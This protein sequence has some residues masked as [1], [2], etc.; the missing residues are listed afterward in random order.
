MM[1]KLTNVNEKHFNILMIVLK[2]I[3]KIVAGKFKRILY[4]KL[5][6]SY[7]KFLK[8]IN[9][10]ADFQPTKVNIKQINLR[11]LSPFF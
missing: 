6:N 2:I 8:S 1:L 4:P 7:F 3:Q 10:Q 9:R 11:K 5:Q